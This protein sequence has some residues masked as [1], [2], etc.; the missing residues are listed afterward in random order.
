MPGIRPLYK[1]LRDPCT[2][3]WLNHIFLNA[4]RYQFGWMEAVTGGVRMG[5]S[6]TVCTMMELLT[7]RG[8]LDEY[9]FPFRPKDYIK[10]LDVCDFGEPVLWSELG[11]GMPA[12]KW[13]Q[14]SNI[15]TGEVV[16]TMMI[17]CPIVFMDVPDL[18][19]VD[20]QVR[21]LIYCFS[22]AKR[23]ESSPVRL[24]VYRISIDRKTGQILF[25]HPIVKANGT[26]HKLRS[27][28][29]RRKPSDNVW[30]I[31]DR[32]QRRYKDDLRARHLKTIEEMESISEV[33]GETIYDLINKV[34]SNKEQYTN[35]KGR[36]DW[37]LIKLH[38]KISENKSKEI[39]K[40]LEKKDVGGS[41]NDT[42][43]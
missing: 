14:L 19:F 38:L 22:E 41:D 1:F 35:A 7:T 17:K 34:E 36:L 9:N 20:V 5:K 15:L 28:R 11:T 31:Y 43:T 39:W 18:S 10:S 16:Q 40:F 37:H 30:E 6:M 42:Y 27:I 3:M 25:P 32:L 4:H 21:K 13:Y 2:K 26:M 29:F 23:W 33:S 8:E 24:W 12:R